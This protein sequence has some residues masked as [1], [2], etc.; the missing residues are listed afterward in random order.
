MKHVLLIL[1]LMLSTFANAQVQLKE[2]RQQLII[3]DKSIQLQFFGYDRAAIYYD[4]LIHKFNN[5]LR[6]FTRGGAGFSRDLYEYNTYKASIY[7]GLSYQLDALPHIFVDASTFGAYGETF[8]SFKGSFYD[9][10]IVH[11]GFE[12]AI[13]FYIDPKRYYRFGILPYANLDIR[14]SKI[15]DK[16]FE[17]C[18]FIAIGRAF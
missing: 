13:R 16:N 4:F 7:T 12:G 11:L 9:T 1:I 15:I 10:K 8:N 14:N 6:L 2:P 5:Q 17:A 3:K 18:L